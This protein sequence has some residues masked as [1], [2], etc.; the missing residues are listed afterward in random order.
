[1]CILMFN[2][3]WD[4]PYLHFPATE[5]HCCLFVSDIAVFVL[6]RDIKLQGTKHCCFFTKLYWLVTKALV[7]KQLTQVTEYENGTP[8]TASSCICHCQSQVWCRG[9]YV[10]TP[11]C[12]WKPEIW[13]F[14]TLIA[15]TDLQCNLQRWLAFIITIHCTGWV[16]MHV[17]Q[18]F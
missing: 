8:G 11:C 9:R 18:P 12:Q 5:H 4:E 7:H 6:K 16:G 13:L 17:F 10:T 1:M 14:S 3:R 15:L 2:W